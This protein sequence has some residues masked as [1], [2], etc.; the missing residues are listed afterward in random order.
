VLLLIEYSVG[1]PVRYFL[2]L[3]LK[4]GIRRDVLWSNSPLG[5]EIETLACL[6]DA[7]VRCRSHPSSLRDADGWNPECPQLD[8][9]QHRWAGVQLVSGYAGSTS[10]VFHDIRFFH[11]S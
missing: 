2:T 11:L 6:K 7:V 8:H 5:H 3:P 1:R 9:E 10:G 4:F